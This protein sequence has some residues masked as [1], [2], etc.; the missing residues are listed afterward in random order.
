MNCAKCGIRM[1]VYVSRIT[2]ERAREVGELFAANFGK[3]PE[4][5]RAGTYRLHSCPNC[6][7]KVVEAPSPNEVISRS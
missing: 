7:Q 5:A 1:D 4:E 6:Q 3:E 2:A